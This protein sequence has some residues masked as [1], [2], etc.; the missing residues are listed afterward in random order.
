MK[1]MQILYHLSRSSWQNL[2][3]SEKNKKVDITDLNLHKQ[4]SRLSR[5][6]YLDGYR[7]IIDFI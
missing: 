3:F 5:E 7:F 4:N 2:K 1:T 6:I